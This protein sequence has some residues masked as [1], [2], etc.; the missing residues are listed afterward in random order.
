MLRSA[1]KNHAHVTVHRRSRRLRGR[2]RR[3]A[4]V[5]RRACRR[6]RNRRLAQKVFHTT[7]L[8]R[9]RHRR[10]PRRRTAE[11]AASAQTFHCGRAEGA[12]PAL[13][14]EPA[15]AARRSTATSCASPS[16]CTARSSRTTTSSTSTRRWR[17][18]SEFLERPEAAVAI[19]KH[20]T[21]CGVGIGRRSARGVGARVRDRSGVAVRRHRR[22]DAAVDAGAGAGR[23]RDLHRGAD[24][25]RRSS[26]TRSSCSRKKKARRLMRWHPEAAPASAPA[27]RSVVGGLLVQDADRA[28]EDVRAGAKVVT[29]RAADRRRAR[30]ARLRLARREAR[31][32][33]RDRASPTR[34]PHARRSAAARR[35]A[36]S[37]CATPRARAER[38]GI[39]LAGL[40]AR[41]RRVL[42]V[43]RR[44][45]GSHRGRR[46]GDRPARRQHA[47]RRGDRGRGRARRRDGLHRRAPLPAL[48]RCASSSSAAAGASTRSCGSSRQAR[49]WSAVWCAPGNAG[50]A[51]MAE[52]VPIAADDVTALVA[53]RARAGDRPDR[54]RARAAA[55]ARPRRPLRRRGAARLRSDAP[56]RR[57]SRAPRRSRRSCCARCSVPTAF[58]GAFDDPDEARRYIDEVGAPLVVKADGLA[59]GKG[60]FICQTVADATRRRSTQVMRRR[61][62]RRGRRARR[63]RGVPR[64]RGAV[65]HGAHRRHD[66]AAARVVAGSQA[67]LRRRRGPEHRRHGRLL[68]R[69]R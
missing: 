48:R 63:G 28:I 66:R 40:G 8:L 65:V 36:S 42:P 20:N 29:K 59:A 58:F 13:R 57:S 6:R 68:A 17:W 43:P 31:Q 18:P 26:P 35:R 44:P 15:P 39:S 32:V 67:R 54:R 64:R 9:R 53:L 21:P 41:Q 2:A 34:R 19:L 51:D 7:G 23:R 69:R 22:L 50:I 47:R 33:E 10:L 55:D 27:M 38:L 62:L 30:G 5:G 11:S 46:D 4:R 60:V 12:R 16:R 1:A 45:R 24:R 56:P 61:R 49:A 3:A 25:A 52:C 37:R 14:R